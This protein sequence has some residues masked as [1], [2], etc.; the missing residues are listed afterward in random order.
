MSEEIVMGTEAFDCGIKKSL[1]NAGAKKIDYVDG[2]KVLSI[3]TFLKSFPPFYLFNSFIYYNESRF[4]SILK[5]SL[6]KMDEFWTTA[7]RLTRTNRWS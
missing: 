4:I 7:N 1:L 3:N 2:S 5:R 6:M